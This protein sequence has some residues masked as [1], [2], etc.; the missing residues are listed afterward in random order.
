METK[1]LRPR[2]VRC[3]RG[4]VIVGVLI[5]TAM[6][7]FGQEDKRTGLLA[8]PKSFSLPME[9]ERDFGASNG[10]ATIIRLMPVYSLP[11]S[12]AWRLV[13]LELITIADAPGG[14]PGRPGNPNPTAG[15]RAFGLSDLI[16]AS[17][18]TPENQAK[19]I[20]GAGFVL[21]LPTATDEVLGSGKWAAGPAIRLVYRFGPWNLGGI[22]GQ[23]WSFAGQS[24]RPDLNALIIRGAFRRQLPSGWYLVSAP[25]ITANW[26]ASSSERWLVP[27]GGGL[28]KR[29]QINSRRWASSLQAYYNAIKPDAAPDWALRLQVVAAIPF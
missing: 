27:I 9:I 13:N 17:F 21:S 19:F 16:H 7:T 22:A 6:P 5:A 20:W 11:L 18:F 25:I 14:V 4:A 15:E 8:P 28:G 12:E 10:D 26:D 29:F 23:R 24:S 2:A 1:Q 3:L